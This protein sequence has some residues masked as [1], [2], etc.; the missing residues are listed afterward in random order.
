MRPILGSVKWRIRKNSKIVKEISSEV[1][2]LVP[3]S[4]PNM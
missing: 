4:A 3:G 1:V 2:K